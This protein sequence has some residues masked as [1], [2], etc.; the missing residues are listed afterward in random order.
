MEKIKVFVVDDNQAA[1]AMLSHM[2]DTQSDM[3]TVGEGGSGKASLPLIEKIKPDV[4]MLEVETGDVLALN[5]IMTQI[6]SID[7]NIHVIVCAA[8]NADEL[9]DPLTASGAEDFIKK[10]YNKAN[11]FRTIRHT[12]TR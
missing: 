4:V 6:R 10:P 12:Q 8:P 9:V 3:E 1:R 11:I 5:E 7:P 2:I